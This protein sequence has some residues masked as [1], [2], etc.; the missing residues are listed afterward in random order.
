MT[1]SWA[2]APRARRTC[3]SVNPDAEVICRRGISY[4][5]GTSASIATESAS[6]T[7]R[8]TRPRTCLSISAQG[9]ARVTAII[10][11]PEKALVTPAASKSLTAAPTWPSLTSGSQMSAISLYVSVIGLS[12]MSHSVSYTVCT[13]D[14]L[15]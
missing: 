14:G 13:S 11:C 5:P 12:S 2:M 4:R 3:S 7:P 1:S 15:G 6:N 10:G 9:R 8:C